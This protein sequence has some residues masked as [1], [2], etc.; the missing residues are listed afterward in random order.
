[1]SWHGRAGVCTHCAPTSTR[2]SRVHETIPQPYRLSFLVGGLF[3]EECRVVARFRVCCV[4]IRE[5]SHE[6][7]VDVLNRVPSAERARG[8]AVSSGEIILHQMGR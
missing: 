5:I 2:A 3:A 7:L 4:G 1:M 8:G 6:G